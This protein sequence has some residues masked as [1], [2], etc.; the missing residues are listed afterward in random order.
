MEQSSSWE[1][2]SSSSSLEILRL[3]WNPKIYYRVHSTPLV[4]IL[5][6]MNP[7]HTFPPYFP[8]MHSNINL[9]STLRSSE[10]SLP[11][12]FS[13]QNIIRISQLSHACYIPRL[14][15]TPWLEQPNNIWWRVQIMKLLIMQSSP[16]S[17]HFV[18]LWTESRTYFVHIFVN[19]LHTIFHNS[20]FSNP[21]VIAVRTDWLGGWL[22]N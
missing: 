1:A 18:N 21:L 9:L 7:V 5:S 3:L 17:R 6:Q 13:N 10:C 22:T 4:P 14:S 16:A 11:F 20:C 12:R 8:D 19:H 15:H 2:D